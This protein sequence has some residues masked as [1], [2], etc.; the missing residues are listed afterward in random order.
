MWDKSN[1]KTKH[2]K[3]DHATTLEDNEIEVTLNNWNLQSDKGATIKVLE[4]HINPYLEW[5]WEVKAKFK[6]DACD[7]PTIQRH[8]TLAKHL[9]AGVVPH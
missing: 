1:H 2:P 9:Q 3:L 4:K 8:N 7:K 5:Y 6:L